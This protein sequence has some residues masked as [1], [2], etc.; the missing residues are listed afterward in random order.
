MMIII[1]LLIKSL[2]ILLA[3]P[4]GYLLLS[5][6]ASYLFKKE[7]PVNNRFLNIGVLIPAH[8]EEEGIRRTIENILASDYPANRFEIFVI[9]DNCTDST[10]NNARKAGAKVFE[11]FDD[12][13]RGKGEALDWFLRNCREHYRQTSAI[14]I[15]DADVCPDKNY[16]REISASLSNPEIQV[17]QAFNGVSNPRAGWR[18]ALVDAAFNVFNHLRMAGSS[19][20]SG[21]AILRGNGMGFRT[22]L[23]KHYGWP[24]H[25]IVEDI[26]F[27]LL[28]LQDGINVHYNPDAVIRSEM[29]TSGKNASSQRNRW[30]GGRFMLVRNMT[31]PLLRLF[32]NTGDSRYLYALAELAVPPLSL[33]VMLFTLATAGSLLLDE[34][35]L[36]YA[37]AF[38]VIMLLYLISGQIQRQASLSTWLYLAAAP[39]YVLWKIP[40]YTGMML[41]NKTNEWVRTTRESGKL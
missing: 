1:Q 36:M 24:S 32:R 30:E 39:L 23:L 15:I 8:N 6:I 17:V 4:A 41:K 19:R 26:E 14:T 37:A 2:L 29:V 12:L 22:E 16:L 3:L 34:G 9:A 35:W 38:W 21:S 5:T 31:L 40:I 28:L 18:P 13:N 10:A 25:S 11:R 27:T 33:L 20:L 7:E